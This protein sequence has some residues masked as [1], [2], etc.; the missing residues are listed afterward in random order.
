M[1]ALKTFLLLAMLRTAR[2][3]GGQL[4]LNKEVLSH[5]LCHCPTILRYLLSGGSAC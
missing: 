5:H 2:R 3:T 4:I 1:Y